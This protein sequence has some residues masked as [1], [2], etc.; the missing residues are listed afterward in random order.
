[1]VRK[2]RNKQNG[3]VRI[4]TKLEYNAIIIEHKNFLKC[5]INNALY[6]QVYFPTR[7]NNK[8]DLIL[9]RNVEFEP[10][11]SLYSPLL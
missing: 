8:L 9:R 5:T 4:L 3:R 11:I 10:A 7:L 1:M 2:N 6:P